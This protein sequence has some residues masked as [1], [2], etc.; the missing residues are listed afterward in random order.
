MSITSVSK[1]KPV[2]ILSWACLM[3][4]AREYLVVRLCLKIVTETCLGVLTG[5]CKSSNLSQF[6]GSRLGYVL[7]CFRSYFLK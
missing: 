7:T 2:V 5:P 3:V 1:I 4:R 6:V